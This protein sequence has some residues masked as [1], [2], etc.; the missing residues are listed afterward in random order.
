MAKLE[1]G[2]MGGFVGKLGP[3]VGYHWRGKWCVRALP[4]S[5]HNPRTEAQQAHRMQFREMVQLAGRFRAAVSTGLHQRALEAGMTECNMFVHRNHGLLGAEGLDYRRLELSHGPVAPVTFGRA[6][7]DEGMVLRVGFEKNPL[8]QRADGA[9]RV[10]LFVYCPGLK[11]GIRTQAVERRVGRVE[12]VLPEEW[13]GEEMHV[14]GFVEDRHGRASRTI[15][16][17]IGGEE[18]S[19]EKGEEA[20]ER[21][22]CA[23]GGRMEG[24]CSQASQEWRD[25]PVDPGLDDG[26]GT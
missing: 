14:Y 24:N 16:V 2:Y 4:R 10:V 21:R 25:V 1:Q 22:D 6:V 12:V 13:R 18:T 9:D 26:G 8:R 19:A 5:V 17:E 7:V 3:A 11:V 23:E 15:Y 20:Q